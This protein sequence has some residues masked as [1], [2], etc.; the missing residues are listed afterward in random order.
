ML[1]FYNL[2][3]LE[4][5]NLLKEISNKLIINSILFYICTDNLV[6]CI[7]HYPLNNSNSKKKTIA[8]FCYGIRQHQVQPTEM[9]VMTLW[10]SKNEPVH[11]IMF[12]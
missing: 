9:P 2:Q 8:M 3:T 11:N 6:L 4:V 7:F 10:V 5:M 1:T 12:F